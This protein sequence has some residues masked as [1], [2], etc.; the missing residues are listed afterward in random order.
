MFEHAVMFSFQ[1]PSEALIVKEKL[2]ALP[3]QIP[4]LLTLRCVVNTLFSDRSADLLLLS[5]FAD[6]AGY[7]EYA[8]HPAHIV[9]KDY[10]NTV[11]IRSTTVDGSIEEDRL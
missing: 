5:S 3:S 9:V 6:E 10:I 2:E 4:T 11:A 7:Q 1:D 8:V